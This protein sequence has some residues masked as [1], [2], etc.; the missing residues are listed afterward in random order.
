MDGGSPGADASSAGRSGLKGR[1]AI[2]E[3]LQVND[4]VREL[5]SSRATEHA[6]RKAGEAGGDADAARGRRRKGRPGP[7]HARGSAP[8]GGQ[9]RSARGGHGAVG[10]AN[11]V[12]RRTLWPTRPRE[13]RSE[14]Q[15]GR[16][17]VL[18]VEDSATIV[19][20]VKY[21]LELEGFEVLVAERWSRRPRIAFE[22]ARTSSSATSTCQAWVGWRW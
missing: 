21:F 22:S 10:P 3:I 6:I 17:R 20:V 4:E 9:Q 15:V 2:H 5:I 13:P 12:C 1:I 19:S 11:R 8:R 14:R 18:V 16:R 7:H